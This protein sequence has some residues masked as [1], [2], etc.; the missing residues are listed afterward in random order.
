MV[1]VMAWVRAVALG[2]SWRVRRTLPLDGEGSLVSSGGD[3][4]ARIEACDRLAWTTAPVEALP[5]AHELAREA[6]AA[7]DR[8]AMADAMRV[9]AWCLQLNGE[10]LSSYEAGMA[11]R[12]L[13]LSLGNVGE[14]ARAASIASQSLTYMGLTDEALALA[15]TAIGEAGESGLAEVALLARN[16]RATALVHGQ[17]H[18]EAIAIWNDIEAEATATGST[19]LRAM[20]HNNLCYTYLDMP[21][22]EHE[23]A[24]SLDEALRSGLFAI[25]LAERLSFAWCLRC[26]LNNT[27]QVLASLGRF[28]AAG[29]MAELAG[30]VPGE[31]GVFMETSNAV[32]HGE[33][34]LL[35]G[36]FQAARDIFGATLETARATHDIEAAVQ[37]GRR[38]AEACAALGDYAGAY[39]AHQLYH[40]S[41]VAMAGQEARWRERVAEVAL[42]ADRLRAEARQLADDVMRDPL[43]R[44]A[45]RRR[46]DTLRR[47]LEGQPFAVVLFD[48]DRFK[49]VNDSY[50][51]AAG[52]DV[53]RRLAELVTGLLA[54][55][56]IAARLGGEEF[57]LI[58]PRSDDTG[59]AGLAEHLRATIEVHDW[60]GIARGLAITASFGVAA[61]AGDETM[62][63]VMAAA[64]RRLYVAKA[65]GRNRVVADDG[66]GD[67]ARLS[68]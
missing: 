15:A 17:R 58:L 55:G 60:N 33:I 11:S 9:L 16:A 66:A 45:N 34:A 42:E 37:A 47:E 48:C 5:L 7:E 23:R 30:A 41:H 64:D 63:Q 32:S 13:W 27:S 20:A 49:Q 46:V 2:K 62:G 61:T 40:D 53:L 24:D 26:A 51:H 67:A 65:A 8:P 56:Q 44:L 14:A 21:V 68:A 57:A 6:L 28:A 3:L 35:A 25:D 18:A 36:D 39:R 29:E 22:A 31:A 43:T 54:P 4:W 19:V 50:S 1:S 12:R 52:D 10:T 59:A 38:L